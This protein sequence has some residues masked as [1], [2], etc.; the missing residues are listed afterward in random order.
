MNRG[1]VCFAAVI[2]LGLWL[3]KREPIAGKQVHV[4]A[5]ALSPLQEI[6]G[7]KPSVQPITADLI[8]KELPPSF[9]VEGITWKTYSEAY[10][11]TAS[12]QMACERHGIW[13]SI[14]FLNWLTG[15][16]Y[17]AYYESTYKTFHT[18]TSTMIGIPFASQ[19]L[20]L[21]YR[22]YNTNKVDDY[23][24]AI[25]TRL[26]SGQPVEVM[27]NSN[28]LYGTPGYSPHSEL[29]IGYDKYNYYVFE[30][31]G[32][33][34]WRK[35]SAY[36]GEQFNMG[37]ISQA[38][39]SFGKGEFGFYWFALL[40]RSVRPLRRDYGSVWRRNAHLL[41]GG[42]LPGKQWL[43]A[44]AMQRFAEDI[45]KKGWSRKLHQL[46]LERAR[47]AQMENATFVLKCFPG[48]EKAREC[49]KELDAAGMAY[50][51]A[52][53]RGGRFRKKSFRINVAIGGRGDGFSGCGTAR[54]AALPRYKTYENRFGIFRRTR[55][56]GHRQVA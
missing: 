52:C 53:H 23:H 34:E 41:A 3:S 38:A 47:Y 19:Y 11:A 8:R 48:N 28:V 7:E 46:G 18:G 33:K 39:E 1:V 6:Y 17:G 4:A 26:A 10:C 43:G 15:Y 24:A 40:D 22:I 9:R 32:R 55:H 13:R 54:L 20:G 35:G 14:H 42:T 2:V 56:I 36:A 37:E 27:V 50:Y 29:I 12:L 21:E 49:A 44:E 45:G 25:K 30:T 31:G 5:P 51:R 16:T